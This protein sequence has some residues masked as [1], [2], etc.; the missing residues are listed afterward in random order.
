MDKE[1]V[2][3]DDAESFVQEVADQVAA[4]RTAVLPADLD[5]L[6][7]EALEELPRR[8]LLSD[9]RVSLEKLVSDFDSRTKG[10]S[11]S[12]T[13][14][15]KKITEIRESWASQAEAINVAYDGTLRE[16]QKD[17]IDGAE[18]TR[19]RKNITNSSL[20]VERCPSLRRRS[21]RRGR[22]ERTSSLSTKP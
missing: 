9:I 16:L 3:I 10:L 12:A 1:E 11:A 19:L 21:L 15:A 5:F 6:S 2:V 22:S 17:N 18:F 8:E 7:E 4:I 14:A 20:S 13:R